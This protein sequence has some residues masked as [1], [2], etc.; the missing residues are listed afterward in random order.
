MET[1]FNF[2]MESGLRDRSPVVKHGILD[3]ALEVINDHGKVCQTLP[4]DFGINIFSNH[5]FTKSFM[6]F[7]R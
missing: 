6:Y 3:A 7:G 2:F 5:F 4:V 1:V